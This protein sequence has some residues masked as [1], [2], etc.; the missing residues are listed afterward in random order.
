M[1]ILFSN[2]S[3]SD[4]LKCFELIAYLGIATQ[5]EFLPYLTCHMVSSSAQ[6]VGS[7]EI[8]KL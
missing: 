1:R 6:I 4:L 3:V 5:D 8:G 2:G 7:L